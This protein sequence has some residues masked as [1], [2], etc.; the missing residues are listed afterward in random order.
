MAWGTILCTVVSGAAYL[1]GLR[2]GA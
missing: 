2:L 1:I